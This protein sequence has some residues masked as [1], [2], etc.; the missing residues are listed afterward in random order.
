MKKVLDKIIGMSKKNK[1]I[2]GVCSIFLIGFIIMVLGVSY[3]DTN[4]GILKDQIVSGLDFKNARLSTADGLSTYT[5]D[6]SNNSGESYSL[7]TISVILTDSSDNKT[8]LIGYIG[9]E[10]SV[11]E[12]KKLM[13]SIDIEL[14]NIVSVEY[15]INK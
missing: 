1:I 9:N 3:S 4:S 15:I 5:V 11:S 8:T 12:S 6:V 7:K 14:T 10:L 2:L 13:A